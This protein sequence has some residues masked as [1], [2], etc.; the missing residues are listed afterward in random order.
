MRTLFQKINIV[1]D[2]R[3]RQ[4]GYVD[5]VTIWVYIL[6]VDLLGGMVWLGL[7]RSLTRVLMCGEETT[8]I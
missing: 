5:N 7:V 1:A 8:I 4:S 3:E 6:P 2:C